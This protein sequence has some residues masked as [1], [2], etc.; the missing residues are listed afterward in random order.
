MSHL[1][2]HTQN[3]INWLN[4]VVVS[5]LRNGGGWFST[6]EIEVHGNDGNDSTENDGGEEEGDSEE[7]DSGEKNCEVESKKTV[8]AS[9]KDDKDNAPIEAGDASGRDDDSTQPQSSRPPSGGPGPAVYIIHNLSKSAGIK[10]KTD[11]DPPSVPLKF[12]S[13]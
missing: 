1:N 3:G 10:M 13:Y 11:D 9:A 5:G 7:E 6:W 8:L 12:F 4:T 2:A